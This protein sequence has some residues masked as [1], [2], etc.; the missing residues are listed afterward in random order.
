MHDFV[1]KVAENTNVLSNL[2][3]STIDLRDKLN[4]VY[5]SQKHP[6]IAQLP[7]SQTGPKPVVSTLTTSTGP[8]T[9]PSTTLGSIGIQV[10]LYPPFTSVISEMEFPFYLMIYARNDHLS[11]RLY[12]NQQTDTCTLILTLNIPPV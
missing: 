3:Y 2:S 1:N 4:Q 11:T 5:N 6:F 12:T 9:G 10:A 8:S 7:R